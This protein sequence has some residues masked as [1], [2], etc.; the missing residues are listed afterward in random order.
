[1]GLPD[2]VYVY[3]GVKYESKNGTSRYF[4]G[5]L[6][7]TSLG[8][9]Q[10]LLRLMEFTNCSLDYAIKT[11]TENPARALGIDDRKGTIAVGK[12]ADL[13]ILDHD[14]SIWSTIAGGKVVFKKI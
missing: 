5:T 3:N 8:L 13:V 6:I 12:D 4:D 7:G 10:L 9:I 2:G 11:V 1:H 14:Y